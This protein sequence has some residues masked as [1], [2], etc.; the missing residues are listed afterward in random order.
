M[1]SKPHN[2][3]IIAA[4]HYSPSLLSSLRYHLRNPTICLLRYYRAYVAIVPDMRRDKSSI[5][6][7]FSIYSTLFI[8]HLIL[9]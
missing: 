9:C 6:N 7:Q 4:P 5:N 8:G 3:V 1:I 2:K